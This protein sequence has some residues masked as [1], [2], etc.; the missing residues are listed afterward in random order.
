[1]GCGKTVGAED[2]SVKLGLGRQRVMGILPMACG[3][4]QKWHGHLAHGL[5]YS[6][7]VGRT[8]PTSKRSEALFNLTARPW[9]LRREHTSMEYHRSVLSTALHG[10]DARATFP[11]V[12]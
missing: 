3:T 4:P 9:R 11:Y 5:Q 1:S 10:Q 7:K 8:R 2:K 6:A 12:E